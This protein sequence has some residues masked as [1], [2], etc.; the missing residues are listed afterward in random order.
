MLQRCGNGVVD[1]GEQC[2]DGNR[3]N[4][5]GCSSTCQV[6]SMSSNNR[7]NSARRVGASMSQ[8]GNGILEAGEQCDDGNTIGG[9]NCDS[10][11]QIEAIRRPFSICGNGV[12]EASEECDSGN[13]AGG[14]GCTANCTKMSMMNQVSDWA[15]ALGLV[16][17]RV[18]ASSSCIPVQQVPNGRTAIQSMT[19]TSAVV[20]V[21]CNDG[22]Q[23][24]GLPDASAVTITCANSVWDSSPVCEPAAASI[25]NECLGCLC[26]AEGCSSGCRSEGDK[27]YCG[28]YSISF[29][30]FQLCQPN[31]G[32]WLTCALDRECS[33]RCV[34]NFVN[35][36][37]PHCTRGRTP[38]CEVSD[39]CHKSL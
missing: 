23:F 6:E 20:E 14:N 10:N 33:E 15:R 5:D 24:R 37:T 17:S 29:Q 22:F 19:P 21:R 13:P 31:G 25:T 9:D 27:W 8:C 1:Q 26:K 35:T 16:N 39:A 34:K 28:P 2:D 12:V 3:A 36:Y 11:C 30:Y 7:P 32:D 18:T 4:G 38:T